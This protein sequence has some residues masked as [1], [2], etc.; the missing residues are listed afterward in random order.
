MRTGAGGFGVA[1]RRVERLKV[2]IALLKQGQWPRQCAPHGQQWA[3][4]YERAKGLSTVNGRI[5][6]FYT[7]TAREAHLCGERGSPAVSGL[8][9]LRMGIKPRKAEASAGW[10]LIAKLLENMF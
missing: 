4:C 6:S 8:S 10:R 9:F 5:L 1:R 7:V 3:M 2:E